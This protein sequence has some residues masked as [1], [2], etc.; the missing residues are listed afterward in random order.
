L[1]PTRAAFLSVLRSWGAEI[2]TS[3]LRTERNEPVGTIKV[4]GGLQSI[5]RDQDRTLSGAMIPSLI[6]ELPLLAVVG[7]QVSGGISDPRCGGVETER[8]RPFA[9]RLLTICARWE[10]RLRSLTTASRFSVQPNCARSG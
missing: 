3:D 5:A 4:T 1:N 7:S 9:E 2:A 10:Q 8:E 6:D